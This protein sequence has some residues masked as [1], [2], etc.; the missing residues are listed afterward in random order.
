MFIEQLAM[1]GKKKES[2]IYS[3]QKSYGDKGEALLFSCAQSWHFIGNLHIGFS[4]K[5]HKMYVY[6]LE[7]NWPLHGT[8]P[9]QTGINKGLLSH[10]SQKVGSEI[11]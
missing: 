9:S 11:R 1:P 2:L 10:I 3:C 7:I 4:G 6:L 8:F 5:N